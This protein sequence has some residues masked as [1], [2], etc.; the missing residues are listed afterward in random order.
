MSQSLIKLT[1]NGDPHKL[2][3]SPQQTLQDI[4]RGDL[5]LIGTKKGCT[6]G[7]CGV[8]T[9]IT[10]DGEAILSCMALAVDWDGREIT[11]IE[12]IEQGGELH[13]IQKSFLEYGAVQCGFCSPG[14]LMTAK[15]LVDRNPKPDDEAINEA[16]AGV[17]CRC[18]GHIKV[19]HAIRNVG[20]FMSKSADD[21]V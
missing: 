14:L 1:V 20:E 4:I 2:A 19:K 15:A 6:T 11:T 12:G 13:P 16:L 8:C 5:G 10:D 3:A 21:D 18:T 9:I 7:S 17:I